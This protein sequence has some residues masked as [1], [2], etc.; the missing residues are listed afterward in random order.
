MLKL[1]I[2]AHI[3]QY[4]VYN[5]PYRLWIYDAIFFLR[6]H[7][8]KCK[9]VLGHWYG[10]FILYACCFRQHCILNQAASSLGAVHSLNTAPKE[11]SVSVGYTVISCVICPGGSLHHPPPKALRKKHVLG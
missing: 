4:A 5:H 6:K 9:S 8:Q 1:E 3:I 11:V 10:L 2:S 7:K